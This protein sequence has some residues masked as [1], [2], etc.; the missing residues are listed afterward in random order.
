MN[1][2]TVVSLIRCVY[3]EEE[4]F[5]KMLHPLPYGEQERHTLLKSKIFS[6]SFIVGTGK[7]RG[8]RKTTWM[9]SFGL[10]NAPATVDG[11][12]SETIIEE[13][14]SSIPGRRKRCR[15]VLRLPHEPLG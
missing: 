9:M 11:K 14:M 13:D 12:H 6:T 7:S 2:L 4:W 15:Q 3:K 8:K 1:D 10:C 5:D